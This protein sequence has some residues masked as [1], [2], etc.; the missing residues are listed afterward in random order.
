MF[1][2]FSSALSEELKFWF[3]NMD[4]F[5]DFSIQPLPSLDETIAT[6]TCIFQ[7]KTL[8][9]SYLLCFAVFCGAATAQEGKGVH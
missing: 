3:S 9:E 4:S 5:N 6:G 2:F 1:L 8:V 7:M